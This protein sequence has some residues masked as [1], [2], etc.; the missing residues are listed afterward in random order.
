LRCTDVVERT[1]A[2]RLLTSHRAYLVFEVKTGE[3]GQREGE[4]SAHGSWCFGK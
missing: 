4:S 3:G 1:P 2:C